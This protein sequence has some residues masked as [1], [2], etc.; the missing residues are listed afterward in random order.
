VDSLRLPISLDGCKLSKPIY[1]Q[2]FCAVQWTISIYLTIQWTISKYITIQWTISIYIYSK[3]LYKAI[4][5]SYLAAWCLKFDLKWVTW[6]LNT[7]NEL[8]GS[9]ML[10]ISLEMNYLAAQF[11]KLDLKWVTWQLDTWN[12]LPGSSMLEISNKSFWRDRNTWI[13]C[14]SSRLLFK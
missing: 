1:K 14:T 11:L 9:S 12:E 3:W 5:K 2:V 7:W 6:Q 8:P 10:E 13:Y 4:T